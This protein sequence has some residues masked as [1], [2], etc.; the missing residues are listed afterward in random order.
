MYTPHNVH[1][2]ENASGWLWAMCRWRFSCLAWQQCVGNQLQNQKE[3]ATQPDAPSAQQ[4]S[5][6]P[7][8]SAL[9]IQHTHSSWQPLCCHNQHHASPA[10]NVPF[11]K[12]M[13]IPTLNTEECSGEKNNTYLTFISWR[14]V[15]CQ[16][17][18]ALR[19]GQRIQR[20]RDSGDDVSLSNQ[21]VRID[22]S[23]T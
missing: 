8:T 10:Q 14:I 6:S 4:P 20:Q 22:K 11:S 18:Q 3:S 12:R 13:L 16:T 5:L 7:L 17:V 2:T 15:R 9:S 1:T 23:H 19:R 21:S